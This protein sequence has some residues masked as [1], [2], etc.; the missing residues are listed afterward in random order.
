[1]TNIVNPADS[2]TIGF[3]YDNANRPETRTFPNGVTTTYTFDRMSRLTRLKD[4][5]QTATLFDRQYEYDN[6]NQIESVTE[7]SRVRNFSYD[8][9]NRLTGMTSPTEPAESYDFD[10]V[11]NRTSSHRSANYG[12]ESGQ[13]NRVSSTDTAGYVYDQNGNIRMKAEGKELWRYQ[14]DFDNRLVSAST[15]KQTVRYKYDALGRRIQRFIVG[16]RENTKFI[17]DGADVIADDNSGTL[18]KYLNGPGIDNKLRMQTGSDVRYF[19]ADHLGSTTALTDSS[20]NVTSSAAYDSF[21]NATGNLATRYKFTGREYDDFTGLHYYRAR[22]YDGNL[23]RFISEDPIGFAGGDVNLYGY[24]G[25]GPLTSTDPS[26][27]IDPSV[28]QDPSI[29]GGG[30]NRSNLTP[31]QFA[32]WSD[33]RIEYASAYYQTDPHAVNTNTAIIFVANLAHGAANLFRVG[34]GLAQAYYCED[35]WQG[36]AAYILMDVE[37]ASG[38]AGIVLGGAVRGGFSSAPSA[39]L[40]KPIPG[41]SGGFSRHPLTLQDEMALEAAKTGAGRRIIKNLGDWRY[42]GLEKWEYKVKSTSGRDSV[43]HYVRNP[44]TGQLMDF[45][46]KK[47]SNGYVPK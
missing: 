29:Y 17:Y 1:M 40:T 16:A 44:Q 2:T 47:H 31:S 9:V 26:G 30:T 42:R 45:K 8:F 6:A 4:T 28:Y 34:D 33:E 24:V 12:Y 21:G 46:F 35:T 22:W 3:T 32:D 20:G 5:S 41:T 19:I 11:G 27:L 18:T 15:R 39:F 38:I 10:K 37:R 14:W 13:F 7:P 36:R 23:G 43:V 25:N